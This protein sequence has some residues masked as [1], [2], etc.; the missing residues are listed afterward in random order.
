VTRQ[1]VLREGRFYICIA[2]FLIL[3]SCGTEKGTSMQQSG[4]ARYSRRRWLGQA[5]AAAGAVAMPFPVRA[6]TVGRGR[7]AAP[8]EIIYNRWNTSAIFRKTQTNEQ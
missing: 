7:V 5:A 6:A 8:S 1:F 4:G 3:L 2:L